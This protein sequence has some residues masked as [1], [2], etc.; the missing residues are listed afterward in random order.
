MRAIGRCTVLAAAS[1]FMIAAHASAN[2]PFR[3]ITL[4]P[5]Q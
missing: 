2:H 3:T 5:T 4:S 1:F